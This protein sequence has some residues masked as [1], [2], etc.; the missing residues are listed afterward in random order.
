MKKNK[1]DN[2]N[3]NTKN[4][5]ETYVKCISGTPN[6]AKYLS[7]SAFNNV[8]TLIFTECKSQEILFSKETNLV[9][10]KFENNI[11]MY[12]AGWISNYICFHIDKSS[13]DDAIREYLNNLKRNIN[14]KK[15]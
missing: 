1:L 4:V 7:L 15:N 3:A 5:L 6:Q 13:S 2:S 11:S 8:I 9:T 14:L 12:A 10:I